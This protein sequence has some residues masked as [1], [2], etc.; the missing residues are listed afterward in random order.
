MKH[1]K[2]IRYKDMING[3]IHKVAVFNENVPLDSVI[4]AI[5]RNDPVEGM[6]ILTEKK[7]QEIFHVSGDRHG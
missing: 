4:L 3:G 2:Y 7:F 1:T 6:L 5:S